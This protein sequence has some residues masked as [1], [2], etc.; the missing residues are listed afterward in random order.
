VRAVME[1]AGARRA[2]LFGQCEGGSMSMLFAATHPERI[3]RGLVLFG[4]LAVNRTRS[5]L[6]EQA[7]AT[8]DQ[9]ERNWG[10]DAS[11]QQI[12]PS[13]LSDDGFRRIWG[14]FERQSASPGA[15]VA[16][17]R[18]NRDIDIR[19]IPP[20]IRVPSLVLHRSDDTAVD[21]GNGRYLAAHI[22]AQST[23]NY[24]A[25]IIFPIPV[26]AIASSTRSKS[27]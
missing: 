21:V 5:W 11:L 22:P 20:Y 6:A 26:T 18:M 1:A 12:A 3:I 16:L 23:L 17:T 19:Y 25:A 24:P 14:R 27:S 13:K 2:A 7:Q 4:A 10:T 15:V 9:M 8:L